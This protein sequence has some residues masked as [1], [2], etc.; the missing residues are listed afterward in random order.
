MALVRW[1]G[2]L[3]KVLG[4]YRH[5]LRGY[6]IAWRPLHQLIRQQCITPPTEY[7]GAVSCHACSSGS[8]PIWAPSTCFPVKTLIQTCRFEYALFNRV[9]VANMS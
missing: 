7:I 5:K 9:A 6:T 8:M 1:A 4:S 2:V 3:A